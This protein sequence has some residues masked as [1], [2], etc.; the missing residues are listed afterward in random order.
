M[1]HVDHRVEYDVTD[2]RYK[3]FIGDSKKLIKTIYPKQLVKRCYGDKYHTPLIKRC[4][5]ERYEHCTVLPSDNISDRTTVCGVADCVIKKYPDELALKNN[6]NQRLKKRDRKHIIDV[7]LV[8][9]Y[10]VEGY[11]RCKTLTYDDMG[12][13]FVILCIIIFIYLS[14]GTK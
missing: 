3:L 8:P 13:I 11:G 10:M 1:E 5:G 6:A 12:I 7:G 14:V 4:W 2:P 9:R